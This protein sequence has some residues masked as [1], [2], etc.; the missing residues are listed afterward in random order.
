MPPT[1][2]GSS[3]V[4]CMQQYVVQCRSLSPCCFYSLCYTDTGTCWV[5]CVIVSFVILSF[6]VIR[7]ILPSQRFSRGTEPLL[8]V[9]D[10]SQWLTSV[11]VTVSIGTTHSKFR[12]APKLRPEPVRQAKVPELRRNHGPLWK[13][14]ADVVPC[15]HG[16][17][18]MSGV[19]FSRMP[20]DPK[21]G[22]SVWR[23][24]S[25]I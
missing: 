16:S 22:T 2:L 7:I 9:F 3:T 19:K 25:D 4:V 8:R 17:V 12:N 11:C 14:A 15:E 21:S 20:P 6:Y 1:P 13:L 24:D 10:E 5:L 23:S 18:K